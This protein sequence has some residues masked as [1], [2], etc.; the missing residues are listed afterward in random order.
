VLAHPFLIGF[1][2]ISL[3]TLHKITS[4]KSHQTVLVLKSMIKQV[5][6]PNFTVIGVEIPRFFKLRSR[7]TAKVLFETVFTF[8]MA[9]ALILTFV[10]SGTLFVL[11]SHTF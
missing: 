8:L 10:L 3:Q 6:L 4:T 2:N 1:L 5:C 7:I 9:S 11:S